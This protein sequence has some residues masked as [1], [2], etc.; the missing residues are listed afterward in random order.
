[1]NHRSTQN[2]FYGVYDGMPWLYALRC[3]V[4][5]G[6]RSSSLA[7]INRGHYSV[8]LNK[9]VSPLRDGSVNRASP[10]K[11][12]C[13][14]YEFYTPAGKSNW[15][16]FWY[17]FPLKSDCSTQSVSVRYEWHIEFKCVFTIPTLRWQIGFGDPFPRFRLT[18]DKGSH[19]SAIVYNWTG[20][21]WSDKSLSDEC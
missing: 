4:Y 19:R 5:V 8:N 16:T 20:K 18:E 11:M 1:M 10:E 9:F 7:Y 21:S 13:L 2:N 17:L 12:W 6:V 3:V 14:L 15:L